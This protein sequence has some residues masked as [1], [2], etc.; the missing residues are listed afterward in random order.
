YR[1][2]GLSPDKMRDLLRF[3]VDRAQLLEKEP[4]FY[5]TLTSNC[6]TVV[7]E[8]MRRIQPKLPL[9]YR[10]LASGYLAEYAADVG[11]LTPGVPLATLQQ[12]GRITLRARE[13]G[14]VADF[15]SRIRV[16]VPG[17]PASGTNP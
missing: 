3:Y 17:I 14:D 6:T 7:F 4:R 2:H 15:S 13:A 9:D 8:L 11:G 10:L 16:G 5:N 12:S 1:L